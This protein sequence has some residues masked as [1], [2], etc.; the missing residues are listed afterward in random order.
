MIAMPPRD[1]REGRGG[2][3]GVGGEGGGQKNRDRG[4]PSHREDAR[5]RDPQGSGL[6]G[7][8]GPQNHQFTFTSDRSLPP[9]RYD[10]DSHRP[11]WWRDALTDRVRE[12]D[13]GFQGGTGEG[14]RV[15]DSHGSGRGG[16]DRRR[17]GSW[18]RQDNGGERKWA[19]IPPH[20]RPLMMYQRE[21]TPEQLEGMVSVGVFSAGTVVV[22][23]VE[24]AVEDVG[25]DESVQMDLD[26]GSVDESREGG[27]SIL[28]NAEQAEQVVVMEGEGEE[29]ENPANAKMDVISMIRNAKSKSVAQQT[30]AN[31][32]A[33]NVDYI[34]FGF[35]DEENDKPHSREEGNH[36]GSTE[37]YARKSQ[38]A[39]DG[40][41]VDVPPPRVTKDKGFHL[42][43]MFH[44]YMG[45]ASPPPTLEDGVML[46]NK[47]IPL[48]WNGMD[49][50]PPG[51]EATLIASSLPPPPSLPPPGL[52]MLPI[53]EKAPVPPGSGGIT[54]SLPPKPPPPALQTKKSAVIKAPQDIISI[55]SSP[56]PE[57]P[58][59]P[60]PSQGMKRKLDEI[61]PNRRNPIAPEY[62]FPPGSTQNSTPWLIHDHSRTFHPSDILHREIHDFITYIRPR[63]YESAV[64]R[65][66][67]HRIHKAITEQKGGLRDAEVRVF[68]S[69]AS[70]MY[71]PTSDLDLAVVSRSY[72]RDRKTRYVGDRI[73]HQVS[74]LLKRARIPRNGKVAVISGAKVP[75]VKFVDA[76]TNLQVDISFENLSGVTALHTFQRWREEYPAMPLLALVIKQFLELR[77]LNEVFQGGLGG[78]SV[79]CMVVSLLQIHPGF[80]S[81]TVPVEQ[82]LGIALMEFLDL[83]GNKFDSSRVGIDVRLGTYFRKPP[84]PRPK[85]GRNGGDHNMWLLHVVDPNDPSNNISK[86]SFGVRNVFNAFAGG[87]TALEARMREVHTAGFDERKHGVL[88]AIMGANYEVMEKQRKTM[89]KIYEEV[90]KVPPK[91]CDSYGES[92]MMEPF[93]WEWDAD[94]DQELN[95]E[96]FYVDLDGKGAEKWRERDSVKEMK[97]KGMKNKEMKNKGVKNKETKKETKKESKKEKKVRKDREKNE[98][99]QLRAQQQEKDKEQRELQPPVKMDIGLVPADHQQ[100]LYQPHA[101]PQSQSEGKDRDQLPK[102]SMPAPAQQHALSLNDLQQQQQ[103]RL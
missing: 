46:P 57:Q 47:P 43:G 71:L 78:F 19:P 86:S 100:Q 55:S 102:P 81:G 6:P 95:L 76:E 67:I 68:G 70:G 4:G 22:E 17:L 83:Y 97:N 15:F 38:R 5:S 54:F 88:G 79:I 14:R 84:P 1:S 34:S 42:S 3:E 96:G 75:I 93:R 39:N 32:V 13:G 94:M 98:R 59:D 66:L 8:G 29:V 45:R 62:R 16:V 2:G 44:Q 82:N 89:R 24:E 18:A 50:G 72:E 10:G 33:N 101:Q 60:S 9:Y 36:N 61:T 65:R 31:E 26:E 40:R 51:A 30:A 64:R 73:L 91:E 77:K 12:L 41:K 87:F 20:Q 63:S 53:G 7:T 11:G 52:S 25:E 23:T 35:S 28:T 69:F 92:D 103:Q 56:E 21:K 80:C 74:S 99:R 58:E 37:D 48:S 27:V 90:F 85:G 49:A